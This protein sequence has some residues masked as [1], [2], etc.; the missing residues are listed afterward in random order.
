MAYIITASSCP[1]P[2][3][4]VGKSH[5]ERASLEQGLWARCFNYQHSLGIS[6]GGRCREVMKRFG[7]CGLSDRTGLCMEGKDKTH[8]LYRQPMQQL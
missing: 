3:L 1:E 8:R 5:S 7:L 2:I 6:K 4:T